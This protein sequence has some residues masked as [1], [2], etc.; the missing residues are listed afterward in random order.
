MSYRDGYNQ[1]QESNDDIRSN[2]SPN[3]AQNNN[4]NSQR[5]FN[6]N[7][8]ESDFNENPNGGMANTQNLIEN[9][10]NNNLENPGYNTN[11]NNYIQKKRPKTSIRWRNVMKID[12]DL[13][14]NSNNLSLLNNYLENFL[15]STITEEDIQAVPE[16]NIVKLIKILQFVNEFLLNSRQ[17]LNENINMLNE[18]RQELNNEHQK[19]EERIMSEKECLD[20]Y[21]KERKLRMK[22]LAD[23]KNAINALLQ[24]GIPNFDFGGKTNITSIDI[25]KKINYNY[26]K[27]GFRGP[28]N[29]YKCKYCIG[30]I[31]SSEFEL[32]KHLNDIHLISQ[33]PDEEINLKSVTQQFPQQINVTM[34]PL[35][36]NANNNNEIY[37]KKLNDMKLEFQQF[38]N[39]TQID[40]LKNQILKQRN[41]NN[42]GDDYRLQLERMGNTFNDTLKQIL[43]VMIKN[44]QEKQKIII[45]P[46]KEEND[47]KNDE[48]INSLRNEIDKFKK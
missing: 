28:M 5:Q 17:N 10:D 20:K 35:N 39:K 36:N 43:G 18:Q 42:L 7:K 37:E 47:I 33:F 40:Q 32:K 1:L 13:I 4:M 8:A 12:L 9:E 27:T 15:Y 14:K 44:N 26:S 24:G 19:L 46:I 16:G 11:Y 3:N 34:P 6:P 31:F 23:Y 22:E 29:G 30:K 45:N 25:N 2:F 48:E 21:N 38:M 41:N